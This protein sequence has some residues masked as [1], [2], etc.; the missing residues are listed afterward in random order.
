MINGGRRT[1]GAELVR[2]LVNDGAEDVA[3]SAG[4]SK[5]EDMELVEEEAV[6]M[7]K[8]SIDEEAIIGVVK[9]VEAGVID[10][11]AIIGVVKEVEAGIELDEEAIGNEAG[12]AVE[13]RWAR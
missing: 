2:I 6:G 7:A 10:E 3:V 12:V 13:A 1:I 9:D 8:L 11:E 4:V 5:Y